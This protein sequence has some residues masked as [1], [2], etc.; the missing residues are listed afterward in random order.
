ME[1]S[2]RLFVKNL[3]PTISEADFRKH[4]SAQGREVT[5]VKLIPHRR[6]GFVGYKSPED[7]ARAVKYFNKSFIRMSRIACDLAKP[8]ADSVPRSAAQKA[9]VPS[10]DGS[11]EAATSLKPRASGVD[12]TTDDDANSKK[13]KRDPV[14]EA[15]PKLQEYLEAMG[16]PAKKVRDQGIAGNVVV[17][18]EM[19]DAVPSALIEA[20][21]SD[22]E[23]EDIPVRSKPSQEAQAG[24]EPASS[25]P[26]ANVTP[27][28]A[29]PLEEPAR[30]VPQVS[31]DATD[32]DWLRSRTNRLL[33]LVDPDDPS[34]SARPASVAVPLAAATSLPTEQSQDAPVA[35]VETQAE[36]AD[37]GVPTKKGSPEDAVKLIEK[38][39]RLFLRNLSYTVTEDDVREH[40]SKFGTLEEVHVPVDNRGKTKGFA[41]IRYEQPE[42]ALSAFQTDGTPFQGRIIHILPADAKRESKLDEYAISQLPL[43]KQQL[44]KKKAEAAS[45]NF[46]W[47]SLFMSQDAVNNAV[48]ER[49]GV[50]KHELLDPTDASAAVKQ[51]VAETT[52]I[53]E[54]KAYFATHGVNIEAFKS[55]QRGDTTILVKNIKNATIEELRT[56]FE[57]HGTVLR[58]LMPPSG[59]IAII[60]FAQPAQCRAA[61]A[62]KAYSRFKDS[63]LYLEKG[64]KDLLVDSTAPAEDRPAGLQKVSVADL[65]ERDDAEDQP[66]TASLFV[67]NLN[68]ST[69][70]EGLTNAF[71][72][73]DGFVSAQVKTKTDPKKPGQVLSMGFGFCS[74]RTKEQAQNAQKVMDG[75][76][77]DGYKLLVK[78]SHRGVDAAEE[79]RR[80]DLAK[81]AAAQRTKVVIKNLPFEASKK[82]VRTLFSTYGK[83][84]ALRIPKKFNHTSRGFAFAEFSTTKE[85][86]NAIT[87]LKDTHFL[88][89]RLVLDFAEAEDLDPEEQIKAMEKKMRGQASKV[90]LQ[91]LTGAGRSKVNIGDNDEDEFSLLNQLG[92]HFM[93]DPTLPTQCRGGGSIETVI[94]SAVLP[95][96]P[97]TS[98]PAY[99]IS[100]LARIL[101]K[102]PFLPRFLPLT[103]AVSV[104]QHESE[105]LFLVSTM[106]IPVRLP[107]LPSQCYSPS[108]D[109]GLENRHGVPTSRQP[110]RESNGNAQHPHMVWYEQIRQLGGVNTNGLTSMLPSIPTPPILPT[111]SLVQDYGSSASSPYPRSQSRQVHPYGHARRRMYG[112][113][114]LMP[115]LTQAFQNYRK[116]Q[117]DKTEQKWPDILEEA[118]V[119]AMLLIP[120]I[121]R[122]KYT[123]KQQLYGRNMLIGEYLWI[124]YCQSLPPGVEPDTLMERGR[125][126]VS[127]HI[128]VL[129]NFFK[130]NRCFHFLFGTRADDKEKES[131]DTISLKN[132]PILIA[133]SES[134][135]PE[136]RPNYEYFAQIL[137]LNDS[138]TVRPKRCWIFVSHQ[139]VIVR[140]D[141]SGFIPTTG[142]KIQES[143][144]PHLA[145]NLERE[146][147]ATEEQQIFKGALL[148]EFTKEMHQD[149]STSVNE[150]YKTWETAFPELHSRLKAITD[151]TTDQRCTILHMNATLEL[152]EKRRFPSQSELNSWVEINIEQP[153]LLNHRWQV[154]TR[155][156]RPAEL[157]YS[158]EDEEPQTVYETSAEIAIQYQHRP[159]CDGPNSR[160]DGRGGRCDCISQRF[161]RDWVT[162]PFPAD[163]WAMTLTNCAEYPAHPLVG[164]SGK[165]RN[166]EAR[167]KKDAGSDDGDGEETSA[168]KARSRPLTQMDLVPKIAMMQEIWSCPPDSPLDRTHQ[169]HRDQ[170]GNG[171]SDGSNNGTKSQNQQRWTRRAVIVW[172]FQT[173]HSIDNQGKLIT[174]QGGKTDWRFL[175]IL[176]PTSD[177]YQRNAIVSP[178]TGGGDSRRGS[179]DEYIGGADSFSRPPMLYR[180]AIMSPSPTYQQ[181]LT[182][183]M[184][185][186]FSSAW[187]TAANTAA[188]Q[189]GAAAYAASQGYNPLVDTYGGLATPP[190]SAT[191]TTSFVNSFDTGVSAPGGVS[192]TDLGSYMVTTT[193]DNN[194]GLG[195]LAAVTD[196]FLDTYSHHQQQQQQHWTTAGTNHHHNQSNEWAP[197]YS[198]ATAT[199]AGISWATASSDTNNKHLQQK[200]QHPQQ[201]PAWMATTSSSNGGDTHSDLWTAA[202]TSDNTTSAMAAANTHQSPSQSQQQQQQL[203]SSTSASAVGVAEIDWAAAHAAAVEDL[204]REWE[205]V[206]NNAVPNLDLPTLVTGATHTTSTASPHSTS[207]T[208]PV[209]VN[210]EEL[211]HTNQLSHQEKIAMEMMAISNGSRNNSTTSTCTSLSMGTN[212]GITKSITGSKRTRSDTFGDDDSDDD[213][214]EYR[215][216][217]SRSQ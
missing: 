181:H 7:A 206:V 165:Q 63:V 145:R 8:I 197:V 161:R 57:E 23:Y 100:R 157:S 69:T 3:P 122:K 200:Q 72:S 24:V 28:V 140:E 20:G 124:A 196:P 214:H 98:S 78:A 191:L 180:E 134:R 52:V 133:L 107:V 12:P 65:L 112:D 176:D 115:L 212:N 109:Y 155:L 104:P 126:Q 186:T 202:S 159:G 30:E 34:F 129:K 151:N 179:G 167:M 27:T 67:R 17:D 95:S 110:L 26:V 138:V 113:N 25:I 111:Q 77:L 199:P 198:P 142:D 94:S 174:A 68:F 163:V 128:Q 141:G 93:F 149:F 137:A 108:P 215:R 58:V 45:N 22:D 177:E 120:Q 175:T 37:A 50:S 56:L 73:L 87:A 61:F 125:K 153:R 187:D 123:I 210:M 209:A 102:K 183:S 152:K 16:H 96:M 33:D 213:E 189:Y 66:E 99:L 135:L 32:D 118:F 64:P 169:Y 194:L 143:E 131:V 160:G 62:R 207:P 43:K 130:N 54:A 105:S 5:D 190:P 139:D 84:V 116:K 106:E 103:A 146:T 47:N 192:Q 82:D 184:S 1:S 92:F 144:Y 88:G 51:A 11:K 60:Q 4:F 170:Y 158:H 13:R 166:R 38:T 44:L 14:E 80:E 193:A 49:L 83:L 55:Q 195:S 40:F 211:H 10:H 171:G 53:Q 168:S 71:K 203:D 148:H 97:L 48:A 201:P 9:N 101:T 85:A 178:G 6:I 79:R 204:S 147:W 41:M 121:R 154:R 59:T 76:V 91:Q 86:L 74:F 127:S 89:R 173:I 19:I 172:T 29:L 117:A 188:S 42:A 136:E 15:N 39:A 36:K 164:N 2:S 31:G 21:E 208:S 182:A 70:T 185:E 132:N 150:L 216:K 81:K 35:V 18:S 205:E 90:A 217:G 46:N 119:D 114:P 75:H 156:V 162:V